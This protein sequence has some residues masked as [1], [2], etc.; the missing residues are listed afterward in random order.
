MRNRIVKLQW[1]IVSIILC[2]P[3]SVFASETGTNPWETVLQN[4][5][6]SFTGPVAYA[7]SIIAIVCSGIMMAFSDLQGGAKYFVQVACGLSIAFFAT[8][9]VTEFLGFTGAVI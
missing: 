5:A 4:I 8:Q 9:I 1:L 7:I 3:V 6:N 2:S